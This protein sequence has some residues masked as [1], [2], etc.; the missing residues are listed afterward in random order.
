MARSITG[1][2][3]SNKGDKTVIVTEHTRKTHPLYKKQYTVTRKFMAHDE[4]NQA[5][6]GDRVMIR[7]CRPLSARKR[8]TLEKI[9]ERGGVKYAAQQSATKVAEPEAEK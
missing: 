1:T 8:F 3:T 5:E 2:V 9:I 7:E 6:V 4:Q